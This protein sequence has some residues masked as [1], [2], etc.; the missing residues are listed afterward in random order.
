MIS[1]GK[2]A[3]S[4]WQTGGGDAVSQMLPGQT[5]PNAAPEVRNGLSLCGVPRQ[6]C[7]AGADGGAAKTQ[8][9][10][11][12]TAWSAPEFWACVFKTNDPYYHQ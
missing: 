10:G 6:T 4:V 9:G 11:E 2:P 5:A 1:G 3:F 12:N 7:C 8:V